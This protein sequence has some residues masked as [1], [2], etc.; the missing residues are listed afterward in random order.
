MLIW[1]KFLVLANEVLSKIQITF[2]ANLH[3]VADIAACTGLYSDRTAHSR[4]QLNHTSVH[5]WQKEPVSFDNTNHVVSK[6]TYRYRVFPF[7]VVSYS[8]EQCS[9]RRYL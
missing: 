7:F 4:V 3:Y 5:R 2:T 8:N 9:R 1:D 6:N